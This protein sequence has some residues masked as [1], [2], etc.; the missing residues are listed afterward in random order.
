MD[1]WLQKMAERGYASQA[2]QARAI[3]MHHTVITRLRSGECNPGAKFIA[4][5]LA[6]GI[7]YED[8][9]RRAA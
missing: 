9:F 8:V 4:A 5:T 2:E 3:D 1:A 6:L 7:P